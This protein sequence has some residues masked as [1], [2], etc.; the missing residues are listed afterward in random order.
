M[1]AISRAAIG[2]LVAIAA[3]GVV[4][5][6]ADEKLF[7]VNS[8]DVGWDTI[9]L[10]ISEIRRDGRISVLRIPHYANRSAIESRFAM[11]A[12]TDIAIQ[13]GFEV[14]IVSDGSITDDV[15]RVGFL[16]SSGEDAAKLLGKDFVGD[17]VLRTEV[18]VINRMCGIERVK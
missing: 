18:R 5:A 15:V 8:K 9:D 12:F 4:C 10:T 16:K 1:N 13:S 6:T 3:A 11:C 14:W 7:R 2:C 17:N